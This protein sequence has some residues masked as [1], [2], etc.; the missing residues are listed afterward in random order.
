MRCHHHGVLTGHGPDALGEGPLGGNEHATGRHR[1]RG[2]RGSRGRVQGRGRDGGR[3]GVEDDGGHVVRRSEQPVLAMAHEVGDAA[4]RRAHHGDA[5]R[6]GLDEHVRHAVAVTVGCDERGQGEHVRALEERHQLA[7]RAGAAERDAVR[8]PQLL[9]PRLEPL[10][11]GPVAVD[12]TPEAVSFGDQLGACVKE[13]EEALLLH[14]ATDGENQRQPRVDGS[15]TRVE[16]LEIDAVVD[17]VHASPTYRVA[18]VFGV[19][20][21]TRDDCARHADPSRERGPRDAVEVTC[22]RG[23]AERDAR[24]PVREEPDQRRIVSE[25]GMDPR[26]GSA[27]PALGTRERG[28]MNSM[29]EARTAR[30]RRVAGCQLL[31]T[32][33]ERNRAQVAHRGP[34][35][36]AEVLGDERRSVAV[37]RGF[38]VVHRCAR[39]SGVIVRV[40][41]MD[42]GHAEHV[43]REPEPFEGQHLVDDERLRQARPAADDVRDPYGAAI[44]LRHRASH[45]SPS[46]RIRSTCAARASPA[47]LG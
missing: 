20:R 25:V 21:A 32:Q 14:Q 42:G 4:D 5:A 29:A 40:G 45:A 43:D 17:E 19:G 27:A 35:Q 36:H 6:H 10:A 23:E 44:V 37:Q 13:V 38:E 11:Q 15:R 39:L 3:N 31:P 34:E 24:E 2:C 46:R 16:P 26:E 41:T 18:D 47:G 28:E 8:Q 30:A 9:A 22:V 33:H 1:F 12:R 7:L